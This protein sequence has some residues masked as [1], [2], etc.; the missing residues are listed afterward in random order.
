M[1]PVW[2]GSPRGAVP[3]PTVV[4]PVRFGHHTPWES[5]SEAAKLEGPRHYLTHFELQTPKKITSAMTGMSPGGT[6]PDWAASAGQVQPQNIGCAG[7][8]LVPT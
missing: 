1:S 5:G 8:C 6:Q 3:I 7:S 4:P 2:L